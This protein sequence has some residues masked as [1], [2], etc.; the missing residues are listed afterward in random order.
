MKLAELRRET[1]EL[2]ASQQRTGR[3]DRWRQLTSD[4][5]AKN[6]ARVVVPDSLEILVSCSFQNTIVIYCDCITR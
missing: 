2:N 6:N 5:A 4:A 1:Q 3:L